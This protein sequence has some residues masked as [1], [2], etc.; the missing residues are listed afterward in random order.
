MCLI[1]KSIKKEVLKESNVLGA[2]DLILNDYGPDKYIGS[3]HIEVEDTLT[4]SDIDKISRRIIS[5]NNCN[6]QKNHYKHIRHY[7]IFIFF[8]NDS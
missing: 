6:K 7:F 2:Y 1:F 3:I 5:E 8:N 4:V